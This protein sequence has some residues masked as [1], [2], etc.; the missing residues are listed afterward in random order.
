MSSPFIALLHWDDELDPDSDVLIPE[1][2]EDSASRQSPGRI[3]VKARSAAKL[4]IFLRSGMGIEQDEYFLGERVVFDAALI[5]GGLPAAALDL[6]LTIVDPD[7]DTVQPS[8]HDLNPEH[9]AAHSEFTPTKSGWHQWRYVSE[10]STEFAWNLPLD[11]DSDV[12]YPDSLGGAAAAHQGRFR[13]LP[14]NV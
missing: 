1:S 3:D 4:K 8:S 9:T 2:F 5:V 14:L 7:G 6:A 13:V 10:A 12:L 11:P